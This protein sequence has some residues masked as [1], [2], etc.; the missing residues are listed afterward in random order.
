[1]KLH[2]HD[3]AATI[4]VTAR[5]ELSEWV[6]V[7]HPEKL[8]NKAGEVELRTAE[9]KLLKPGEWLCFQ[10]TKSPRQGWAA[11]HHR[12]LY[13]YLDL[14]DFGSIDSVRRIL[15]IEG[16]TH[17]DQSG[18][19]IVRMQDDKVMKVDLRRHNGAVLLSPGN[20]RAQV[21]QYDESSLV[22]LPAG[23]SMLT[24]YDFKHEVEAIDY[25]DWS[26]D[27]DYAA[28]VVRALCSAHDTRADELIVWL[29]KHAQTASQQLTADSK[30]LMAAHDALRSGNLAKQLAQ[31]RALLRQI[32]DAFRRDPKTS[33]LLEEEAAAAREEIKKAAR[34]QAQVEIEREMQETRRT[35]LL[36]VQKEV[37][38]YEKAKRE[39]VESMVTCRAADAARELEANQE[40]RRSELNRE[41][42]AVREQHER[43]LANVRQQHNH[44]VGEVEALNKLVADLETNATDLR[45][46][47]IASLLRLE[48]L[49]QEQERVHSQTKDSYNAVPTKL[50]RAIM[51]IRAPTSERVVKPGALGKSIRDF[52]LLTSKGKEIMEQFVALMLAGDVPILVGT[53]SSDFLRICEFLVSGGVSVRMQAD[54]T[55]I[56]FEDLWIRA[57]TGLPTALS[58]ARNMAE[59]GASPTLLCTVDRIER[60]GAMYWYPTLARHA[61][62]GDFPREMLLCCT[63]EDIDCEESVNLRDHAVLLDITGA[64]AGNAAL[65][66][67]A[68][69]AGKNAACL[70]VGERAEDLLLGMGV[71]AD[72]GVNLTI[73]AALRAARTII[74]AGRLG[75][76]APNKE[77]A[78]AFAR[79]FARPQ[80]ASLQDTAAQH[81]QNRI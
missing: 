61:R 38:A 78:G 42:A 40:A 53:E 25:I 31:D 35:K 57:G 72:A 29:E 14:S 43:E 68:A 67:A 48:Q 56:T 2:E 11:A 4:G 63:V 16:V 39:E 55:L 34:L 77:L 8:F 59:Q 10:V 69:L 30:D 70:E 20:L 44:I 19:W 37:T 24:L 74:E 12:R 65:I 80:S 45:D 49:Q 62:D 36:A 75:A 50:N 6:T 73:S 46:K 32:A 54:P 1:M 7:P 13:R 21:Y 41:Y 79:L 5:W 9:A 47:E 3:I 22:Q 23:S 71:M 26:P 18:A 52:P 81:Q 64:I 58:E 51:P 60:S 15:T 33:R 17:A 66:A 76:G 27:P 28:R